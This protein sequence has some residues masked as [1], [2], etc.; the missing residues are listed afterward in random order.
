[1]DSVRELFD[2]VAVVTA[3]DQWESLSGED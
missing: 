3:A 2:C 1:L